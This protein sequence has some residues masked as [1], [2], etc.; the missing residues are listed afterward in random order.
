MYGRPV[1]KAMLMRSYFCGHFMAHPWT[2][3]W[4]LHS[5]RNFSRRIFKDQGL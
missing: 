4:G 1:S 5:G 3:S 2:L